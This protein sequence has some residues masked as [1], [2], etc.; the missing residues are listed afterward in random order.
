MLS[1]FEASSSISSPQL[2]YSIVF[3]LRLIEAP[4]SIVSRTTHLGLA[5]PF[6]VVLNPV[7]CK[8]AHQAGRFSVVLIHSLL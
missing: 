1:G 6:S 5:G 7:L 2:V 8:Y 3:S 4:A